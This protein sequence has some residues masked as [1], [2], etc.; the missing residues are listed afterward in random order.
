LNSPDGGSREIEPEGEKLH[1]LFVAVEIT[2]E[3]ITDE[4]AAPMRIESRKDIPK[5]T[6]GNR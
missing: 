2:L 6:H 5:V 4:G 3:D 1:P